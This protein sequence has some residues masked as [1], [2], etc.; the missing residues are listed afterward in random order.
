V[1]GRLVPHGT[2]TPEL[3]EA[4]GVPPSAPAAR[5]RFERFEDLVAEGL[6]TLAERWSEQLERID[7]QV[8][9]VPPA[10]E[11]TAGAG[12]EDDPVPLSITVPAQ[13]SGR[14]ATRPLIVVLRGPIEARALDELDKAEL[15]LDVLIHELA[16]LLGVG[17]EV[18]DPE[19]H[20]EDDDE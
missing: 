16:D 19:G 4:F 20:G 6:D 7:V 15:V 9:Q 5:T 13:G 11:A 1:R 8:W 12:W 18:I 2:G 3:D 10:E 17:P 14:G